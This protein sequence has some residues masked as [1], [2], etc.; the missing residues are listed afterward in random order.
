MMFRQNVHFERFYIEL[1]LYVKFLVLH[2]ITIFNTITTTTIAIIFDC[3]CLL[4]RVRSV[5]R[6]VK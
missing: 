1:Q 5:M 3:V 2:Y 6:L 4:N